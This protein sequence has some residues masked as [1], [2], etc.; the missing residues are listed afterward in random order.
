[1][2]FAYVD[3]VYIHGGSYANHPANVAAAEEA[4]KKRML[5]SDDNIIFEESD[6]LNL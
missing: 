1:M 5:P 2:L 3:I 6:S 4:S